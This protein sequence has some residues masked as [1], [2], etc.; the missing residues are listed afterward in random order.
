MLG[1]SILAATATHAQN[2]STI[3]TFDD[4]SPVYDELIP[5]GYHGLQWNNFFIENGLNAP[6][7]HNGAVSPPNVAFNGLGD[8]AGFSS[9]SMF[10]L[11][12]AYF[13]AVYVGAQQ[14]RAQGF[15]AGIQTYDN[16]Y[17]VDDI[18]PTLLNFNYSEV[19]QVRFTIVSSP[20]SIFAM[21]NLVVV[22]PEPSI[23][24]L[25]SVG[26]F[27]G[28]FGLLRRKVNREERT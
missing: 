20:G 13:T 3:L 11:Q 26:V 1:F 28:A 24:S 21:D 22:V 4:V 6:G 18:A 12:P 14:I 25:L 9:G 5:N 7:F 10:T 8:P 16:T 23:C 17:T 27:L 19:D 15:S 2:G